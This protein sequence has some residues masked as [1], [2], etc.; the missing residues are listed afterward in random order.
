[1]TDY[2]KAPR[3]RGAFLLSGFLPTAL[4]DRFIDPSI[5]AKA[6]ILFVLL[7][8]RFRGDERVDGYGKIAAPN[9]PIA[10]FSSA[11]FFASA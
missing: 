9:A 7:G 10:V 4:H 1:M 5:P 2:E 8:P 3:Q 6:G 11:A